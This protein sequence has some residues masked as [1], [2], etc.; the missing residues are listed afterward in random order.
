MIR[1]PPRSTLFPYTTLFRSIKVLS[2]T[3]KQWARI[4]STGVRTKVLVC[5]RTP[6]VQVFLESCSL[7]HI[8][9][10]SYTIRRRVPEIA[11]ADTLH[12]DEKVKA[13]PSCIECD[14]KAIPW[15]RITNNSLVAGI[16]ISTFTEI[17]F[18]I[19]VQ[20]HIH[21]VTGSPAIT[22][23]RLIIL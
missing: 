4:E 12:E 22:P 9:I 3:S 16:I 18:L 14:T 21:H 23:R 8:N 6:V 1:R 5:S 7:P 20:V 13:L 10:S 11:L 17:Y 15:H 19:A 2:T